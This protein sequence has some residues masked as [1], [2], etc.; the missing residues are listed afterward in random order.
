MTPARRPRRRYGNQRA[1]LRMPTSV[2][3]ACKVRTAMTCIARVVT[4]EPTVETASATQNRTYPRCSSS[5][6]TPRTL[7]G[8]AL[9]PGCLDD[10]AHLVRVCTAPVPG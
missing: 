3:L 7:Q 5:P 8:S 2:P 4:D 6:G 9:R 1:A 10:L